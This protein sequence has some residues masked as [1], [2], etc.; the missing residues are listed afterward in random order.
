MTLWVSDHN[1]TVQHTQTCACS[2]CPTFT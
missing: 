1:Q 2:Y